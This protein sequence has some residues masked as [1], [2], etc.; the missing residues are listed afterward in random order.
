MLTAR[1]AQEAHDPVVLYAFELPRVLISYS[2]NFRRI[3]AVV[4]HG[5]EGC[6][7]VPCLCARTEN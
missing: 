4:R 3:L 5:Y 1:R 6:G 2:E 7:P